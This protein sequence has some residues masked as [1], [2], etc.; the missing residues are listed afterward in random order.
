MLARLATALL[1]IAL[2]SGC[3]EDGLD[4]V[5]GDAGDAPSNIPSGEPAAGDDAG[6]AATHGQPQRTESDVTVTREGGDGKYVARKTVTLRNDFG[7]ASSSSLSLKTVNGGVTVG[8]WDDGGYRTIASLSARADTE[9]AARANL[10]RLSVAHSDKLAAGKLTLSTTIQFPANVQGLGGSLQ[11]DV[12][13]EPA[14]FLSMQTT[15][16][17]LLAGGIGGPSASAKTTNG[18]IELAASFNSV[19]ADTSNGGVRLV[20]T[21]NRGDVSTS[22]GGVSG[23]IRSTASGSWDVSTTNGLIALSFDGGSD[24][25]YDA[26][27]SC[28]NGSVDLDVEGGEAVG[29]Q[30]RTS[31]HVRTSGFASKAV[32]V[33]L[34]LSTTNGDVELSA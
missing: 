7:G 24:H 4:P 30:S 1:L 34:D 32:Q 18:G 12:P 13:E 9:E 2:L 11:S 5:S 14:Y 23:S 16:G 25:G 3:V 31:K 21:F 29:T 19:V 8:A 17:G 10:A 20:G 22:N 33:T 15:N 26:S 27:G 6:T 28:T